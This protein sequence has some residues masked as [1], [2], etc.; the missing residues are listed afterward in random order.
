MPLLICQSK[1]NI[2]SCYTEK[3]VDGKNLIQNKNEKK[4]KAVFCTE[5]KQR[6][7]N[8]V[9]PSLKGVTDHVTEEEHSQPSSLE[10]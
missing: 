1:L 10:T 2:L 6:Y 9:I 3:Q 8:I 5:K 7:Q 4:I